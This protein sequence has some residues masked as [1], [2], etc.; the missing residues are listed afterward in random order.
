MAF[1]GWRSLKRSK[2][3]RGK[4]VE[5]QHMITGPGAPEREG[6]FSTGFL[7]R[8]DRWLIKQNDQKSVDYRDPTHWKE[9]KEK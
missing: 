5:V 4:I 7:I 3:E 9:I 1:T 8:K 2:P 6:W